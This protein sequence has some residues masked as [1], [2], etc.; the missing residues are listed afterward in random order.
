MKGSVSSVTEAVRH[1][2]N[3]A[4]LENIRQIRICLLILARIRI[5]PAPY[6]PIEF[7]PS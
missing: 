1:R 7:F 5:L 3:V 2:V 4:I 6:F